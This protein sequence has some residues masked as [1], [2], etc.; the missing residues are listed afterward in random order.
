MLLV[1]DDEDPTIS[2]IP[3]SITVN[4][5]VGSASA[6]VTWT[7]PTATDNSG[8]VALT[9]SHSPGSTFDIGTTDVTYTAIDDAGNTVSD[10][11]TLTVEGRHMVGNCTNLFYFLF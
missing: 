6:E 8:I 10:T 5:D 9:S 2:N 7:E 3:S 11:F 1:L 4:T